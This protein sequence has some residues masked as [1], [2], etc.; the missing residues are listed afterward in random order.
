MPRDPPYIIRAYG[1]DMS[2]RFSNKLVLRVQLQKHSIPRQNEWWYQ[3]WM[4]QKF[5]H[6]II[7][8]ETKLSLRKS[9]N[10]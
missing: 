10:Q 1:A 8:N 3:V 9:L 4:K 2:A 5:E 7:Q 6:Q